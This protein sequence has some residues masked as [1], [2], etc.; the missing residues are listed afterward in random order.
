M[1]AERATV[2]MLCYA[3]LCMSLTRSMPSC[4]A[5]S[6]LSSFCRLICSCCAWTVSLTAAR[7]ASASLSCS[8]RR[9]ALALLSSVEVMAVS[10]T[11]EADTSKTSAAG[12]G[13]QWL[14]CLRGGKAY[15]GRQ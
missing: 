6:S 4:V 8:A 1:S 3:E 12:V 15:C 10:G 13:R 14:L 11:I 2:S 9:T 5:C 7:D